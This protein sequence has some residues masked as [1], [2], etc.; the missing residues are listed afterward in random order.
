M[1]QNGQYENITEFI[2]FEVTYCFVVGYVYDKIRNLKEVTNLLRVAAVSVLV[3]RG[4]LVR[5]GRILMG[6]GVE[7]MRR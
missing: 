1:V 2:V 4:G 7:N 6:E 3:G 5:G